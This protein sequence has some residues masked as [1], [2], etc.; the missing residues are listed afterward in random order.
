M[1]RHSVTVAAILLSST[2]AS[3]V[4]YGQQAAAP[5]EPQSIGVVNYLDPVNN[6]LKPLPR[7]PTQAVVHTGIVH[8]SG[9]VQIPGPIRSFGSSSP[10][11][12]SS[13]SPL[14]RVQA[15]TGT[16]FTPSQPRRRFARSRSPMSRFGEAIKRFRGW[17][18]TG[19]HP[20]T[21][22]PLTSSLIRGWGRANMPSWYITM[23]SPSALTPNDSRLAPKS[24]S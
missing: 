19:I 20:G 13:W 9:R 22:I 18:Y 16:S 8:A 21:A 10:K 24:C 14:L 23:R 7:Q 5:A 12:W 15:R 17:I 6:T 4:A 1:F 11:P 3:S 2:F